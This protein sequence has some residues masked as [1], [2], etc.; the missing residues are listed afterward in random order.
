MGT[1]VAAA[2]VL[3]GAVVAVVTQAEGEGGGE[4]GAAVVVARRLG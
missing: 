4:A 3:I 2:Q 1:G